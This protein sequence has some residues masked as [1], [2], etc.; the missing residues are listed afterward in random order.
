MVVLRMFTS[1][2]ADPRF[3]LLLLVP[4][5]IVWTHQHLDEADEG[6]KQL[7][8]KSPVR[9]AVATVMVLYLALV[10]QASTQTFIY[11]NF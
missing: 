6:K 4:I 11:F 8:S 1:G 9:V 7:L 5:A 3:P 10:N 2:W